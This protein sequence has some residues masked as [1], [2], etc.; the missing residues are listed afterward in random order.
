MESCGSDSWETT[1]NNVRSQWVTGPS[2]ETWTNKPRSPQ[3]FTSLQ[4][5]FL[6]IWAPLP[7]CLIKA[8]VQT[9]KGKIGG[10]PIAYCFPTSCNTTVIYWMVSMPWQQVD[11]C[12][13]LWVLL[14]D[15]VGHFKSITYNHQNWRLVINGKSK[16]KLIPHY[17]LKTIDCRLIK[18][19]LILQDFGFFSLLHG[20]LSIPN[21]RVILHI[22]Q[23]NNTNY[24]TP[25]NY[26]YSPVLFIWL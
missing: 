24:N 23:G 26:D 19:F 4:T 7:V 21:S 10:V 15:L 3:P 17:L 16:A 22:K 14:L 18:W 20:Y 1:C 8:E 6:W 13:G 5:P 9:K 25:V 11:K 2:D 12:V